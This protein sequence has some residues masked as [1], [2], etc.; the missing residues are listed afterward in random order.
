M[1]AL[2][3]TVERIISARPIV[4]PDS[5]FGLSRCHKWLEECVATHTNCRKPLSGAA[6]EDIDPSEVLP[7]RVIDVGISYN[8]SPRLFL[9]SG[10]RKSYVALSYCWGSPSDHPTED[11]PLL[12]TT[13]NSLSQFLVEIPTSQLPKTIKDAISVTRGLGIRHLW[14]D[15]LCIIQ[16]NPEDWRT[17]SENM[18]QIFQ[19]ATCTIAAAASENSNGGLFVPR[20][21][22]ITVLPDGSAHRNYIK[23]P[24]KANG[25]YLGD[26]CVSATSAFQNEMIDQ[27]DREM[28]ISRWNHRAWV[29]QEILLSRRVIYYAREELYFECQEKFVAER[30][31]TSVEGVRLQSKRSVFGRLQRETT[32]ASQIAASSDALSTLRALSYLTKDKAKDV[33]GIGFQYVPAEA[34]QRFWARVVTRYNVT[35][36]TLEEDKLVA[37]LGIAKAFEARTKLTYCAG[38]WIEDIARHLFWCAEAHP[39]I[40]L[41]NSGGTLLCLFF[42]CL[43]ELTCW[44]HRLGV[45]RLGKVPSSSLHMLASMTMPDL[46]S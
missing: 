34:Q 5:V 18:G 35:S 40:R 25:H 22:D 1:N 3:T 29:V 9:S 11:M 24:C 16:D 19:N 13:E 46:E 38:V 23:F 8:D 21:T 4:P 28:D 36:L 33:M 10:E 43:W 14:V 6:I 2:R 42:L 39:L 45:G 17:E 44:K 26:M 32:W 7:T 31:S 20:Y 12:K 37:I 41:K 30:S 27:F 15:S